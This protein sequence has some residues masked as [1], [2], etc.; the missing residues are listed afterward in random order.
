MQQVN[1]LNLLKQMQVKLCARFLFP[2]MNQLTMRNLSLLIFF[3]HL[4]L[5]L[6]LCPTLCF[7]ILQIE[8]M[9]ETFPKS[10]NTKGVNAAS[11]LL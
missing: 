5:I 6:L 11:K 9:N 2:S 1:M 3:F 4:S 7:I 8:V 10:I